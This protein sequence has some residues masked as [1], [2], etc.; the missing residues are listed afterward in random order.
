M[1]GTLIALYSLCLATSVLAI[2][3]DDTKAEHSSESSAVRRKRPALTE[4]QKT[5]RKEVL[6][7]YDT[8]KDGRL[9]KEERK[10][11]SEGDKAKLKKAGLQAG[12]RK[13][14]KKS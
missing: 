9:D 14:P 3:A 8:N 1:N 2:R 11:I 13:A 6:S 10:A 4:E 7:K 12:A 5:A